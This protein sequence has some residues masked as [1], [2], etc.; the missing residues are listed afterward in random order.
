[1]AYT[2]LNAMN[3][4]L[5]RVGVIQGDTD[6][7]ATSTVTSTATGLTATEA[8]TISAIQRQVD[9]ALQLWN[10]VLHEAYSYGLFPNIASTATIS[11]V[12]DTREY[13]LP[14]DFENTAG[15]TEAARVMRGATTGL[16]LTE[17]P[18]G[19]AQMLADQV[20]ATD[21]TGDPQHYAISP[22]NGQLRV[23]R[24]PTSDQNGDVYNLL[25]EK[26]IGFTSTQATEG[27]PCS[28]SAVDSFVPVIA[29][30]YERVMKDDFD[31]AIFQASFTRAMNFLTRVQH[32]DRWGIGH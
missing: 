21:W 7:L 14:S 22:R 17:Y 24:H 31:P 23:D 10:E 6:V 4:T 8:F 13:A 15:E 19:Y 3:A 26:R 27:F 5:R 1:M 28:D 12:T 16:T 32:K 20:V 2:I 9:V 29:N 18:G 11:L 25:Y 30:A